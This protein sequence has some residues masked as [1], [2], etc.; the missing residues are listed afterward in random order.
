MGRNRLVSTATEHVTHQ[1]Q[2]GATLKHWHR[3]FASFTERTAP[4]HAHTMLVR[5]PLH[6]NR[7]CCTCLSHK[8][9]Y[10]AFASSGQRTAPEHACN[11]LVR[12][13]LQSWLAWCKKG[14]VQKIASPARNRF[15]GI[16]RNY[17]FLR[18][19]N[20]FEFSTSSTSSASTGNQLYSQPSHRQPVISAAQPQA[21]SACG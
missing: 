7:V 15:S 10:R 13:R 11:L 4:K 1:S 2:T 9:C 6:C 19:F 8:N 21:N 3:A 17:Y 20:T 12:R 14:R 16:L 5:R 18:N